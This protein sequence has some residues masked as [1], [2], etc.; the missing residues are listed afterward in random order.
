MKWCMI[1]DYSTEADMLDLWQNC[2]QASCII[3]SYSQGF[4][5]LE[6]AEQP[7]FDSNYEELMRPMEVTTSVKYNVVQ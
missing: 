3:Y 1:C 2:L 6:H 5:C 7:F 4:M